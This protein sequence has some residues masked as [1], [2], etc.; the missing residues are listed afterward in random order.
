M[1]AACEFSQGFLVRD[2]GGPGDV[3]PDG[4]PCTSLATECVADTLRV[5]TQVGAPA[6]DFPCGWGCVAGD[7]PR[8][9]AVVP[10]GSGGNPNN[11]VRPN[12]VVGDGLGD[13]TLGD[14][15][16]IDSDNGRIGTTASPN[17][18]HSTTPGIENGIDF[19]FRGPLSMFR[20]KS[21]TITGTVTVIGRRPTA[22]VADGAIQIN[23]ILDARGLCSSNIGGPGGFNGGSTQG[24]AGQAPAAT[25]AGGAGATAS[26]GG[27]GGGHGTSGG[28]GKD[29]DAGL[30]FGDAVISVL[31]GGA[32]GG[33]GGGGG[34]FGR[35]G[36][37]GGA[38]Q[39]ISNTRV[40][41]PAG[42]GINAG[43]C[44]GE[45]GDG[46]SDSGGGGGA[47]GVILIEAPRAQVAG[48]LAVNGGGGG[49]GG[50]AAADQGSDGSLSRTP[51]SGGKGDAAD[52]GGGSGG[53]GATLPTAGGAG[54]NPGGGG[55]A[56]GRIRINTRDGT[57][58]MLDGATLSPA[59]GDP[60]TTFSTGSATAQ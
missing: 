31:V 20:F 12:D 35:G 29:A 13:V 7:P 40:V 50:G 58:S 14:G 34:M 39:L 8:C 1:A 54:S 37:G 9:A 23:G 47:G 56:I 41:V 38:L 52:E 57:G 17:L 27:G 42:G 55:G 46:N 32:G 43:G 4:S 21:L 18:H 53:A 25:M 19:Q 16:T 15:V 44:G 28:S 11:G 22:F 6:M 26:S 51:A 36:G 30:A 2:D 49:G 60:N 33:A 48:T 24:S 5:C 59:P 45:S 3:L 10:S